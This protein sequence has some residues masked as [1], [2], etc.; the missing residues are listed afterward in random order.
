MA[1]V[2][3]FTAEEIYEQIP[4][5]KE[6]SIHLTSLPM[7]QKN[8]LNPALESRWEK[9]LELREAVTKVLEDMRQKKEIGNSLEAHVILQ[10]S[11][12][13]RTL[14]EET[15]FDLSALFI[16]SHVTLKEAPSLSILA[17][18]TSG[19]KCERCWIWSESVTDSKPI[20]TK[21]QKQIREIG[22]YPIY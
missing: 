9:L 1:P 7:V 2:L 6:A 15:S 14:L 19:K 17:V 18:K 20:C 5:K 11:K 22:T 4:G 3:S 12:E 13:W 8:D 16:V 21:C 10:V